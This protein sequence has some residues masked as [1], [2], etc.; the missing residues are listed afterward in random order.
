MS[1]IGYLCLDDGAVV[2]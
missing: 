2:D 1:L